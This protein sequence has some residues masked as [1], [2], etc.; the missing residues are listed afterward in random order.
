M[1]LSKIAIH[2]KNLLNK[3][4]KLNIGGTDER[5]LEQAIEN[6]LKEMEKTGKSNMNPDTEG[7]QEKEKEKPNYFSGTGVSLD[8][9]GIKIL[10]NL[11]WRFLKK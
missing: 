7:E 3:N 1:I 2:Q 11:E 4:F 9:A 6:S 5:D 8:S 10:E